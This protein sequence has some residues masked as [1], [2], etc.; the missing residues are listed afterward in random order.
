MVPALAARAATAPPLRMGFFYC[1]N[2]IQ[3]DFMNPKTVGTDWA[4]RSAVRTPG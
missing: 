1:P 4:L 2:G 3:I